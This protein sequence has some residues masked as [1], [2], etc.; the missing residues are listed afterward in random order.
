MTAT[1]DQLSERSSA[2]EERTVRGGEV[3][4]AIPVAP[5]ILPAMRRKRR[6]PLVSGRAGRTSLCWLHFADVAKQ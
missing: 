4:G 1:E 5:T 2:Y 6:V 3:A